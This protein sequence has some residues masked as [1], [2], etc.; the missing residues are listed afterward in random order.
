[1]NG[2]LILIRHA[3]V[4]ERYHGRCYGRSDVELSLAG[5]RHSEELSQFFATRPVSRI[6][7]S[8]LQ[9]TRFLAD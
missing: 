3:A 6:L 1:M 2:E 4:S 5:E 8:G 9:R 7:H